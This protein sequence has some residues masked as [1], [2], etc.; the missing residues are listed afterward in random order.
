M[1]NRTTHREQGSTLP[2]ML[3]A[4]V[5]VTLVV[6]AV[7][8]FVARKYAAPLPI[9]GDARAVDRQYRLTLYVVGVLFVFA[10]LALAGAV[11]V[12]RDRGQ[13]ARHFRGKNSLE[14]LWTTAAIVVCLGLG[15]LG[16]KAWAAVRYQGA[17]SGSL[18][19]E[20]TAV[21]FQFVFRYPGPDGTFGRID[22][23]LIS[24]DTGNSLGLDQY[25]PAGRDDIITTGT[26]AVPVG[27]PVELLIRSQDV[28]HNFFVRELRL[29]QDAVPGLTVPIHFTADR[30]GRY[31]IVC[32]QLCGLGH[33][34]MHAALQ[35]MTEPDY[36]NFLKQRA[37]NQ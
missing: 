35:V 19:I 34:R 14:L 15:A 28:I 26:L 31:D 20:V 29:Q 16:R 12:F 25:S 6:H 17:E 10:Q 9:T 32:T 33:S 24:A 7:V 8:F 36:E 27:R 23:A 13:K 1:A 30:V 2:A 11:F 37:A 21:Q 4:L 18:Q 22:P 3:F 5:I